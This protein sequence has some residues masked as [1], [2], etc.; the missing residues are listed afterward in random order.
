ML[1]E[2]TG[3]EH[4]FFGARYNVYSGLCAYCGY[5][6]GVLGNFE[7]GEDLLQKG[8]PFGLEVQSVY[9]LG[10]LE[11]LY[12]QL[13]VAKGDGPNVIAHCEKSIG[14]LEKAQAVFLV[15]VVW[16]LL[17]YG[18]SLLRKPETAKRY[19]E[20]GLK[21][22]TDAGQTFL[23]S[24]LFWLLGAVYFEL[25]DPMNAESYMK[26]SLHLAKKRSEKHWE[27]CSR[28]W[29]GRI[30]EKTGRATSDKTKDYI[31]QGIRLL[32][33]LKIE[34]F[35]AQGYLFLGEY[36]LDSG[37]LEFALENL[38]KAERMFERMGMDYWLG[39]TRKILARL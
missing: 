11:F 24:E 18:Y 37:Q 38:N 36:Y 31:V 14:Y 9:G 13:F 26:R 16:C 23:L 35:S 19:I 3:R 7:K 21:I 34:P 2:K 8:I 33:E 12:G 28:M 1:L 39:K 22:H 10:F 4:D 5:A 6:F 29:L 15:G 17:G 27:G 32:D 20:K 25:G 30:S